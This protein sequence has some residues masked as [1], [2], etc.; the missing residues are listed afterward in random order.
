VVGPQPEERFLMANYV[1]IAYSVTSQLFGPGSGIPVWAWGAA[2]VM[3]F[4]GL[5]VSQSQDG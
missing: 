1:D 3:I 4:F 5:L 2:L